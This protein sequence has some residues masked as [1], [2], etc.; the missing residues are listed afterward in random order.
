MPAMPPDIHLVVEG[1]TD[2]Q[3]VRRVLAWVGLPYGRAYV[4]HGKAALLQHLPMYNQAAC[5]GHWLV[6][7]DLDQDAECA[8]AFVSAQ[9]PNPSSGM[10]M[11]VAVRAAEAWL[12]ADAERLSAFLGFRSWRNI[13]SNPD[14]LP[15]P[16]QT[17]VTLASASRSRALR[18]DMVPRPGSGAKI[19][20][21]YPSRLIEFVQ[22]S[23]VG[24]R[25][26]V[27]L[28]HSDSLRRL[29]DALE[30]LKRDQ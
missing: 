30:T 19:G 14:L 23:A 25:P 26:E 2:E 29:V 3:V 20:P 8:P 7:V 10:L 18:E 24:W 9:L 16:K 12:L 21:G 5:W 4:Q 22:P 1:P 17:L 27:A 11:R 28:L 6:V 15:D 13:P